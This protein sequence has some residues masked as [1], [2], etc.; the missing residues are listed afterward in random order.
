M[1]ANLNIFN[2]KVRGILVRNKIIDIN[3]LDQVFEEARNAKKS[4]ATLVIEKSLVPEKK[5]ITLLAKE[6]NI[7][8]ID[9]EKVKPDKEVLKAITKETAETYR[10]FP[11]SKLGNILTLAMGD[12]SDM[13]QLDNLKIVTG[14]EIRPV[15]ASEKGITTAIEKGYAAAGPDREAVDN[16]MDSLDD[17]TKGG[18]LEVAKNNTMDELDSGLL[19]ENA[20]PVIKVVNITVYDAVKGKVSDIHIEPFEKYIRVRYRT[21]GALR[22][23]RR[24]PKKMLSAISSRIKIMCGAPM[25]IAERRRPQDGKFRIKME[26]R[27]VDFRVS[28]LPTIHGEKTVMRILDGSNLA[29]NLDSLGFEPKCLADFQKAIN[30]P[31]GMVL[32]TGP[33]GS[34]KSTTLY[35]ALKEVLCE[36]DN[37]VT[38]EDPVEYQMEG[39][40]QVPASQMRLDKDEDGKKESPFALALR[41]ILRQ[42]P[43]IVMIGEIR[44]LETISIAVK[45]AL[46]GHVVFSTL[47]TNDAPSTI[48]RIIDMGVDP[49]MVAASLLIA[50]AQRLGRKLCPNCKQPTTFEPAHLL[51]LGYTEEEIP[52]AT[53]FKPVGCGKCT[54]GYKGRFAILETLPVTEGVQRCIISRGSSLD[55]K[56][57]GMKEGMISLRRCALLNAMRGKTSIEQVMELTLKD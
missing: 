19:D 8:P 49:F 43:D 6:M 28:I 57:V 27:Q 35:S 30:S 36:E 5:M 11:I 53:F 26:G 34:G 1:Q 17:P 38:V 24:L 46:T 41:S 40:N 47:H 29:L 39:V 21:D 18:N 32:V 15:L 50:S 7:A 42:D 25:D 23:V 2:R 12:P 13:M 51:D 45:A 16:F 48:S 56:A 44:D 54:A 33:T 52:Q 55:L 10:I 14:C 9:I 20:A 37:I 3:Q 22:E 31:Y 4:V